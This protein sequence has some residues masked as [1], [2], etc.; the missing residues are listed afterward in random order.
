MII[1]SQLVYYILIAI[2]LIIIIL[3]WFIWS[4]LIGAGFEP[5]S[6]RRVKRMLEMAKLKGEDVVYDL[7]SGDGRIVTMAACKYKVRSV[8]IEADPIRLAW[9]RL[10]A[11]LIRCPGRASFIWGNFFR[12]DINQATVVTIFL[13]AKA[14]QKLKYKLLTELEPG[15][16]V[17]SYYWRITGWRTIK[18]D[19]ENHLYLYIIGQTHHQFYGDRDKF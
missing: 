18:E 5:T 11:F 14:N 10:R 12:E 9:S 2:I 8:G 17:V 19:R 7:G 1:N 4:D 13:S 6:T 16:R 3:F 15:T